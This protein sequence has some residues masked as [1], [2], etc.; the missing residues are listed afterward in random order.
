MHV[1]ECTY[2][3]KELSNSYRE[4][5]F[6]VSSVMVRILGGVFETGMHK[7]RTVQ[8]SS[9]LTEQNDYTIHIVHE[10]EVVSM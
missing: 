6:T 5:H 4:I 3:Y 9:I 1:I 8:F 10:L 2:L 7:F